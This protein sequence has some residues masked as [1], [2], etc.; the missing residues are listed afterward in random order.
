MAMKATS[1]MGLLGL[2]L[3]VAIG[4]LGLYLYTPDKSRSE[5]EARYLKAEDQM[6]SVLGT[7]IRVRDT[8]PKDGLYPPVILIHGFGSSLETWDGWSSL[9]EGDRRVLR[10]DLP[11]SGLSFGDTGGDYSDARTMALLAGLMDAKG[12]STADIIGNSIGGRIAWRFAGA[13]PD[14]VRRLVLVSPDG[15]AS[16]GFEYGKPPVVPPLLSAMVWTLPKGLLKLNLDPSYGDP[17]RL[18]PQTVTRYHDLMLG[19][20]SRAA[21]LARTKQTILTDPAAILPKIK[22]ATL[23][24]WG[25]KDALI[26]ISNAQDYLRLMPDAKLVALSGLGHVPFE[27]APALSIVPVRPFLNQREP[28]SP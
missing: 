8:G 28:I 15:F 10:L 22:A 3:V 27:E 6:I 16:P 2:F 5:L 17:S 19:P 4:G 20:S 11:G 14:R 24:L 21:L 7:K 18:S 13:Y 9:L 25:E 26:P 1:I 12:V 23:L